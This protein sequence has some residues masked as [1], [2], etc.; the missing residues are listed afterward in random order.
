MHSSI[1]VC[2]N[3]LWYTIYHYLTNVKFL[4]NGHLLKIF[5]GRPI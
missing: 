4:Q 1:F 2:S 5:D 3:L